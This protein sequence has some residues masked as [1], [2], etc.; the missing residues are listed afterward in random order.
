MVALLFA[1]RFVYRVALSFSCL[2][3]FLVRRGLRH[4]LGDIV[5][6]PVPTRQGLNARVG[7]GRVACAWRASSRCRLRAYICISPRSS[8][9]CGY[10][11]AFGNSEACVACSCRVLLSQHGVTSLQEMAQLH[12]RDGRNRL[13]KQMSLGVARPMLMDSV[14]LRPSPST[15]KPCVM[16]MLGRYG[17]NV[18]H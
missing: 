16:D 7:G 11:V 13:A 10:S 14:G 5:A 6:R 15:P 8:A 4:L 12:G 17:A 1:A 9:T 3:W 18:S 2:S